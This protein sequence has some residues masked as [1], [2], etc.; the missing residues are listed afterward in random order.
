VFPGFIGPG[1]PPGGIGRM[2]TS[3]IMIFGGKGSRL[4]G[5]IPIVMVPKSGIVIWKHSGFRAGIGR[6]T[7]VGDDP[8]ELETVVFDNRIN[9]VV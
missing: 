1:W 9:C 8:S 5:Q 6:I 7:K 4:G 2:V 3:G